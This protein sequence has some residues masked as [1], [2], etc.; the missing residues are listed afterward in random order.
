M[1]SELDVNNAAAMA[2]NA[3]AGNVTLE[4]EYAANIIGALAADWMEL[5][6]KEVS[7]KRKAAAES[8][9]KVHGDLL[10]LAQELEDIPESGTV[11]IE[12]ALRDIARG[13][14]FARESIRPEHV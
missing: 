4:K 1:L 8:M 11:L 6:G 5:G 7:H 12:T 14:A 10:A 13:A 2:A 3:Q 9:D